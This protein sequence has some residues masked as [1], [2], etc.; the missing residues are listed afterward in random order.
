MEQLENLVVNLIWGAVV[1]MFVLWVLGLLLK[2]G[3]AFVHVL[4]VIA[5]VLIGINLL[6]HH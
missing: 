5:V 2:I 1:I 4:L 6:S 3:G